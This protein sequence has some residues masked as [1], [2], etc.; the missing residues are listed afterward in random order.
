RGVDPGALPRARVR[1]RTGR[2]AR[3]G[4]RKDP[5]PSSAPRATGRG[6]GRA[7]ARRSGRRGRKLNA[8]RITI[9]V[10]PRASRSQVTGWRDG[11]LL[12]KVTAPPVDSAANAAVIDLLSSTLDLPKR[13]IRIVRGG[14][15]RTKQIEVEGLTP[16]ELRTRLA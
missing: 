6:D 12:V 11:T 5:P 7:A 1:A 8:T 16:E 4:R 9:R 10:T 15:S 2:R 13:A 14:T 3:A